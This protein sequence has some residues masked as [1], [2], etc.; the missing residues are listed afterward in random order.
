M[1]NVFEIFNDKYI[2]DFPTEMYGDYF[3]I[4]LYHIA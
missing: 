3:N 4:S 1:L 2:I